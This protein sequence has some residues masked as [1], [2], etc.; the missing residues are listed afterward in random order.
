MNTTPP[1]TTAPAAEPSGQPARG[2]VT[3][4]DRLVDDLA[5]TYEG[6]FPRDS[7]AEAVANPEA[8][9]PTATIPD[10]LPILVSRF[11]KE[12]PAAAAQADG[13]LIKPVPELLFVCVQNAGRSQMAAALAQHLSAGKVHV[14]SAGSK[15]ADKINPMAVR[16]L[17]ERGHADR[18]VSEAVN[19]GRCARRRRHCDHG[20][21]RC[22]SDLS[23]QAIPRLGRRRS[24]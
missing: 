2:R 24:Q 1:E 13:R 14:R 21:R 8:L 7:I 11:A 15:P 20:L 10:F 3:D 12:Q 17:A 16:V 23:R 18:G 6:I 5:Y 4:Y 9:E 19:E 22:L